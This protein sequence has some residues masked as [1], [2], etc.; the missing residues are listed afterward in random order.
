MFPEKS[1]SSLVWRAFSCF[2]GDWANSGY[3][4]GPYDYVLLLKNQH[5]NSAME[6]PKM[7]LPQI[8]HGLFFGNS[9]IET[10]GKMG[11]P[12]FLSIWISLLY[13]SAGSIDIHLL[14]KAPCLPSWSQL[15][16]SPR[17][18]VPCAALSRMIRASSSRWHG[19]SMRQ[20]NFAGA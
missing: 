2:I 15:M 11:V 20:P 9:C 18:C 12:P 3:H 5:K 6:V 8:F 10:H 19:G 17:S 14:E 16:G 13:E 7:E 4:A 1:S